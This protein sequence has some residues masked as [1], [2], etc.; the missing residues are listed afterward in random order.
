[1]KTKMTQR[2]SLLLLCVLAFSLTARAAMLRV[3][4]VTDG[5]TIVVEREG[6]RETVALGGVTLVDATRARDLLYWMLRGSWV[7]LESAPDG[8]QLVYRS[9]DALFMNRELVLR[10]YARATLRE[11]STDAQLIV[12]YIGEIDPPAAPHA[13]VSASGSRTGSGT[14]RRSQAAPKRRT[15][16]SDASARSSRPPAA[17]GGRPSGS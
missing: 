10:G 7:M 1:M 3:V 4:D 8:G 15:A 5:R 14:D 6:R 12:T 9:P 2:F 17:R 16:R 11:V 13:R